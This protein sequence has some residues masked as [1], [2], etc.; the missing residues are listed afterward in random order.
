MRQRVDSLINL[1]VGPMK[2]NY[3]SAAVTR[4]LGTDEWRERVERGEPLGVVFR[5]TFARQFKRLGFQ[6]A[7]HMEIRAHGSETPVYDLV[8]ASR[9]PRGIDFWKKIQSIRP[10]GQRELF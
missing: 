10:S 5:E 3:S 9:S 8:F 1:P 7:E 6:T 2:R 4:V